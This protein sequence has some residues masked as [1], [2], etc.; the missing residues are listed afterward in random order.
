VKKHEE[1]TARESTAGGGWTRRHLLGALGTLGTVA[2]GAPLTARA[3]EGAR[4]IRLILPVGAGSGVDVITRSAGPALTAALGSP[5]IIENQPGAGGII[6]TSMLVRSAPD[7]YTLGMLS[8]N[9]VIYPSV[10]KSVPFDPI[11]DI[12]P[13]SV[14]GSSPFLLVANPKTVQ[15][16]DAAGLIAL[17]KANPHKYNYASSGTGTIL[18]LAMEMFLQQAHVH[19]RHIPYKGVGPMVT[20]LIGGQVDLGVLSLPSVLP[21]VKTGALRAIG[22]CGRQRSEVAPDIPTL[23]EQGLSDY[24][25]A[26]WFAVAGPAHMKTADVQRI[27]A[28]FQRAFTSPDVTK[29]MAAQGNHIDLMTPDRSAAYFRSEMHKYAAIVKGAGLQPQ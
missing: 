23:R 8:N 2:L 11:A 7:G 1:Q 29:A 20:D 27:Y 3:Q 6:G 14:V 28:G 5:V 10:Y 16:R 15:A 4:P 12:T 19:A 17:L 9:H 21:H 13:I 24:D 26:G 22:A 25:A 18:Q